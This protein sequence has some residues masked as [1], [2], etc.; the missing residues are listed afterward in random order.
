[1]PQ[2]MTMWS[3]SSTKEDLSQLAERIDG[4]VSQFRLN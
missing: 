1:M 2:P 4:M 3:L